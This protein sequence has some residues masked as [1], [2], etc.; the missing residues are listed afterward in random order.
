MSGK[1]HHYTSNMGDPD[2]PR[3]ICSCGH[4]EPF[5]D[6]FG[7]D[8]NAALERMNQHIRSH[9]SDAEWDALMQTSKL[10]TLNTWTGEL[11][12]PPKG[13]KS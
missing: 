3:L 13:P 12:M 1:D 7:A 6:S 5:E 2:A 11:K 10:A 4:A 9:Y 8:F